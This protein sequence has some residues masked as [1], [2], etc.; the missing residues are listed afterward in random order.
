MLLAFNALLYLSALAVAVAA[1]RPQEGPRPRGERAA[2]VTLVAGGGMTVGAALGLMAAG[3][4][5]ESAIAGSLAI[6]VVGASMWFGLTRTPAEAP[7]EDEEDDD[8]GGGSL[9]RPPAPEPTRPEGGP[10]DEFQTDWNDFDAARA[11]WS[12]EREPASA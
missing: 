5:F 8:G 2:R 10:T 4:W 9:Y 3:R 6:V 11:G 1:T 12:R 7:D